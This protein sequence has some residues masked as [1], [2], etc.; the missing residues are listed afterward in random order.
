MIKNKM[1]ADKKYFEINK[2]NG[3]KSGYNPHNCKGDGS[4]QQNFN[5]KWIL[6]Y[7]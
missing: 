3:L 5:S 6:D 1:R 2:I 4:A 7:Q